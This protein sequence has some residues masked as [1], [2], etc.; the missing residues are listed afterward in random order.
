MEKTVIETDRLILRRWEDS[1]AEA[2]FRYAKDPLVG[3][4][5]GW[6]PHRSVDDSL[7]IIRTV[8]SAPETYAVVLKS[9]GEP[10]GS[11][12]IMSFQS[13]HSAA[14]LEDEAEI[15]Y[16]RG[17]PYWGNGY[18]PEAVN[19]LVDRCFRCLGKSTVWIGHYDG[20]AQSRAVAIKCGFAYN[21]SE[22]D[23]LSPLGDVRTEHFL[24]L[25]SEDYFSRSFE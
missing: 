7:E 25:R 15:G 16:W 18:I 20:N 12:G 14:M 19:A 24:K 6:P 11:C 5:A 10:V 22:Y 17:V 13:V 9:T 8:F 3:P 2:L 1:D 4:V 21:H 23:K